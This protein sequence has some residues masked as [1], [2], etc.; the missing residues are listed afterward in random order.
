V[1]YLK[2]VARDT[3]QQNYFNRLEIILSDTETIVV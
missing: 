1:L 2:S 3:I